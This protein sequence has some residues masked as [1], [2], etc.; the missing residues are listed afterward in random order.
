MSSLTLTP[1]GRPPSEDITGYTINGCVSLTRRR[2]AA[3]Q[4][5]LVD[6]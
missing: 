4:T 6:W 5:H 1:L 3:P 2:P